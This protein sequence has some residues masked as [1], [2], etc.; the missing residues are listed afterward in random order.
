MQFKEYMRYCRNLGF[1]QTP[2]YR[3]L[4][5]LFKTA[6]EERV[7][8]T[9]DS[10][11]QGFKNDGVYDWVTLT[12]RFNDAK[13]PKHCLNASGM[14]LTDLKFPAPPEYREMYKEGTISGG[15]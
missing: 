11:V 2:D 9:A 7:G 1:D 14:M 4:R 6:L 5:R 13:L 12:G 10:D 8:I 3:F 15:V